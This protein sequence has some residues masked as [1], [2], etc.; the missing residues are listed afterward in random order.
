[1][2]IGAHGAVADLLGDLGVTVD[3]LAVE[4][5]VDL[6]RVVDLGQRV[7]RELDVDDRADDATTRSEV[8]VGGGLGRCFSTRGH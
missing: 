7:G 2:Q 6:E 1:M 8:S 3:R 4:L 5:D